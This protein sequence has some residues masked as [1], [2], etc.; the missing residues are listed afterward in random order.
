[1]VEVGLLRFVVFCD[2][3]VVATEKDNKRNEAR[4]DPKK[5][6][7]LEIFLFGNTVF[8]SFVPMTRTTKENR[9]R[10]KKTIDQFI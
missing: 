7:T 8:G 1:M 6:L 4:R 3:G 10:K 9:K 5:N 2:G